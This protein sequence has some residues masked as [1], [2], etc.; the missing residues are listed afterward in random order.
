MTR[1]VTVVQ[2]DPICDDQS[3]CTAL[4]DKHPSSPESRMYGQ[5]EESLQSEVSGC[6][7][8]T[9]T[10]EPIRLASSDST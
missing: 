8:G 1:E 3:T 2:D 6:V 9:G 4:A 5:V 10:I 7:G